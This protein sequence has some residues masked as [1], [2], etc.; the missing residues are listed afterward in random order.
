MAQSDAG[1]SH[2]PVL[3]RSELDIRTQARR[4]PLHRLSQM[5]QGRSVFP[6]SAEPQ[7]YIRRIDPDSAEAEGA[8]LRSRRRSRRDARQ[9]IEL[10]NTSTPWDRTR[11]AHLLRLRYPRTGWK[12]T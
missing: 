3:L 10:R 1:H 11:H 2:A 5:Q 8:K 4:H 12:A 7:R 6:K 9:G